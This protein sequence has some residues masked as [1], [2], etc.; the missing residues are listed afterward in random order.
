MAYKNL[1][2]KLLL[3]HLIAFINNRT[4]PDD[5]GEKYAEKN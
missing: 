5:G 3:M 2:F 1:V 4:R